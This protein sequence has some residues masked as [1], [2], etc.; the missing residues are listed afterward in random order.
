MTLS[1]SLTEL[2]PVTLPTDASAYSSWSTARRDANVSGRDVPSATKVMAVIA[3]PRP[4]TQPKSE[5]SSPTTAVQMPM[6][7]S[8]TKKAGQP[9]YHVSGG[10]K[11]NC[12]YAHAR[13]T[14]KWACR[15]QR[16]GVRRSAG[17]PLRAGRACAALRRGRARTFQKSESACMTESNAVGADS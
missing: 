6:K 10:T 11:A 1:A 2:E 4:T 9:R 13:G 17:R 3:S 7:T 16:A 14:R 15:D 5:A 12:T 8:E